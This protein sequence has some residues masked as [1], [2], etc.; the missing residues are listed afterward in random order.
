[1]LLRTRTFG[2]HPFSVPI[3]AFAILTWPV[4]PE[5][6]TFKPSLLDIALA[7]AYALLAVL[8]VAAE[9]RAPMLSDGRA[10]SP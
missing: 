6:A 1:M 4:W 3:I 5:Y 7:A 9:R 10:H 8:F 2:A